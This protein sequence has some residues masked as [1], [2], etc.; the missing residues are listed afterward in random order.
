[1]T[2]LS[3]RG[4]RLMQIGHYYAREPNILSADKGLLTKSQNLHHLLSSKKVC[5]KGSSNRGMNR[6]PEG[7]RSRLS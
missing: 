2:L 3:K 5:G 1:M 4:A 6:E 7:T